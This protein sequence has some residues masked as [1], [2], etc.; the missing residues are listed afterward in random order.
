M[1][2]T[3]IDVC[4]CWHGPWWSVG[5]DGT[6]YGGHWWSRKPRRV[7]KGVI[8]MAD[9]NPEDA[10]ESGWGILFQPQC[11]SR[12]SY[13]SCFVG[14]SEV[15][16]SIV[17]VA[18][19]RGSTWS[20]P[21]ELLEFPKTVV[22]R[23]HHLTAVPWP[24]LFHFF[25][26]DALWRMYP[27]FDSWRDGVWL[28]LDHSSFPPRLGSLTNHSSRQDGLRVVTPCNHSFHQASN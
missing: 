12:E 17:P 28:L 23:T 21:H 18:Q 7:H 20:G 16:G 4:I 2:Y 3:A 13:L 24:E 1:L 14:V 8:C 11:R 25:G 22:A 27:N 6:Q 10:E 26:L 15:K 19:N 5:R 9:L